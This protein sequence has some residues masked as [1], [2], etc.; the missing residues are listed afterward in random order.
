VRFAR[1][2]IAVDSLA[3]GDMEEARRHAESGLAVARQIRADVP[4]MLSLLAEIEERAGD[5]RKAR[6]YLAAV[7]LV[8]ELLTRH[9]RTIAAIRVAL[10]TGDDDFLRDALDLELLREAERGGH[11][12]VALQLTCAFAAALDRLGR[13]D[14]ALELGERALSAIDSPFNLAWEIIALA[15]LMP[16][17][18]ARLRGVV[19]SVPTARLGPLNAALLAM[20]DAIAARE[21]GSV[22]ACTAFAHDGARRFAGIGW[23][24]PQA[25]CL[26]LVG[27]RAGATLIY[28]RLG[29]AADVRR[30][31]RTARNGDAAVLS[32][33]ERELANLIAEGKNNREAAL[34]LS[35]TVKA[36]EKYLT[37]I[38]QKLGV[39]SRTQLAG[40]VI[41]GRPEGALN[42]RH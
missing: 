27:D 41:S 22:E 7:A 31:E 26:E 30:A 36:V 42:R 2:T 18:A 25:R 38:Y 9:V 24:L 13:R 39:T 34:A 17:Q 11:K 29:C 23:P 21:A 10:A 20:L 8:P 3:L 37:S 33:R 28:R 15:E 4:Y 1:G 32:P 14:E 5:F 6:D 19:T 35:V 40:H 16:A 12:N